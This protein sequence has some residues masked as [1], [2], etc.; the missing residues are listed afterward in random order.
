MD[1][2][3]EVVYRY[4]RENAIEDGVLIDVTEQAKETGILLPT[5]ITNHLHHFWKKFPP[6]V[7]DRT[8]GGVYTMCCG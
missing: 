6:K 1:E 8:G 5:V 3:P 2:E 4:A 7:P